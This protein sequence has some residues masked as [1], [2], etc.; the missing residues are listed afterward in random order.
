MTRN[1]NLLP[2]TTCPW[3]VGNDASVIPHYNQ[4]KADGLL[5]TVGEGDAFRQVMACHGSTDERPVACKGYLAREGW[6]NLSVRLLLI[7]EQIESPDAVANACEAAGVVLEP[8]Y[9]AV[10]AKLTGEQKE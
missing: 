3:R 5:N 10:L 4:C 6:S 2:C 1:N 7:Q 9:S 8:D